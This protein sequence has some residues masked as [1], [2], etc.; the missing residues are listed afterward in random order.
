MSSLKLSV[1][2]YVNVSTECHLKAIKH[3]WHGNLIALT[4]PAE[5]RH[6]NTE[7]AEWDMT[8]STAGDASNE[9]EQ[10]RPKTLQH[11][12]VVNRRRWLP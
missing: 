5:L 4:L 2:F 8:G 11:L 10:Q 6:V 9:E 7:H 1:I 3:H 12:Q